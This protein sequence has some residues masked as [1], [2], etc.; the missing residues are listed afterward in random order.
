[1]SEHCPL[2]GALL[3]PHKH[4]NRSSLSLTQL[5][6]G[7]ELQSLCVVQS[8]A[9]AAKQKD[10]KDFSCLRSIDSVHSLSEF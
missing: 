9:F 3:S 4:L 5:V 8:L 1:M 2:M 6:L 10:K 7:M